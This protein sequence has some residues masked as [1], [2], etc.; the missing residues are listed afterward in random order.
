MKRYLNECNFYTLCWCLFLAKDS[1]YQS[2]S[3]SVAF[4]AIIMAMSAFYMGQVFLRY[5]QQPVV[6]AYN[7][8]VIMYIVYGIYSILFMG[9]INKSGNII[10]AD[11]FLQNAMKSLVPFYAFFVFAMK[12]HI[13][14]NWLC[15]WAL[16]FI[17]LCIPRYYVEE[18]KMVTLLLAK[19]SS[20]DEVT[21]NAGYL[22]TALL[23]LLCFWNKK[24][25]IQYVG[26]GVCVFF[27]VA[28]MKRGAILVAVLSLG[29]YFYHYLKDSSSSKKAMAL[30]LI[31]LF[32]VLCYFYVS[33]MMVTSAY[34]EQRVNDT[35]EGNTSNRSNLYNSF[36]HMFWNNSN[37]F[38]LLIGNGADSTVRYG[39]NFA[40]NDWLEIA[41]NQGLL[42]IAIFATFWKRLYSFWQ[43]TK[44]YSVLYVAVGVC[45]IQM[46]SKTMF[47]MSI[48]DM[49]IYVT[50][51]LGY[52]VA[53]IQRPEL[54]DDL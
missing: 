13:N 52:A 1:L 21:N 9:D 3:I 32:C 17:A 2:D 36:W 48:T 23:P 33:N 6:K 19:G 42:G 18:S 20:A 38:A 31:M 4:Y 44:A 12:G 22:F 39:E 10:R 47:S 40:H 27:V 28:A 54:A 26:F 34:F 50:L 15:C 51:V 24:P 14:K 5:S 7:I 41:M 25:V 16:V 46:L 45:F 49:Q 11:M 29:F 53:I 43:S 37:V 35:I 30:F 8:I